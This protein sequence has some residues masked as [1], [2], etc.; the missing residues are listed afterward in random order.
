MGTTGEWRDRRVLITGATGFIGHYLVERALRSGAVVTT[1]S[2]SR[3]TIPGASAHIALDLGLRSEVWK[4]LQDL[5]PAAILHAA[6]SGV[7]EKVEFPEMLRSNVAGTDNLLSAAASLSNPPSVVMAGSGY[8]YAAQSR[9]LT[10]DD[11]IFPASLYGISKAAATYCAAHYATRMPITVLRVFNVYGP[12]ERLPRLLPFIVQNARAGS[13]VELTACDQIRDF[14]HVR[15]LASLF[16]R[17]LDCS[18]ENGELRTLNVGSGSPEPLRVFVCTVAR[19]LQENGVR[20]QVKFGV[21]AYRGGEPMYYA[22]N[23]SRM[24]AILGNPPLTRLEVGVRNTVES[25]L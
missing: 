21:L 4:S 19:V 2:R 10:E 11:P 1:L 18:P 16:W 7:T 15:D 9:P 12:G 20:A 8:E 23:T 6:A 5:E 22:A 24:A 14:I 25:L 3:A 13:P 17:A